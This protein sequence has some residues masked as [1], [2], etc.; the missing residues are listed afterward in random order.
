VS[1]AMREQCWIIHG[2]PVEP[3]PA[4]VDL[5]FARKRHHEYIEQL[6]TDGLLVSHGA[7]RDE[8]GQR[9][10]TGLIVIRAATRPEAAAIAQREPYIEMGI[11]RL[12]LVPWQMQRGRT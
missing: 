12:K 7:T 1:V 3:P 2:L 11:R 4:D 9:Y 5:D 10:G 8:R 6:D